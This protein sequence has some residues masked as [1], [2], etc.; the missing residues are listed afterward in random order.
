M[1]LFLINAV[2]LR[3]V[4]FVP[5]AELEQFHTQLGVY[6]SWVSSVIQSSEPTDVSTL[7]LVRDA[8]PRGSQRCAT[9]HIVSHCI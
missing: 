8:L 6:S 2:P 1:S 4:P 7:E 3:M 5:Q 9:P